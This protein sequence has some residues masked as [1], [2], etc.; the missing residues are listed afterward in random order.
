MRLI[1]GLNFITQE[2]E[3]IAS[4]V[5]LDKVF[6]ARRSKFLVIKALTNILLSGISPEQ[7]DIDVRLDECL[8]LFS[9][10]HFGAGIED[11]F[12]SSN[13]GHDQIVYSLMRVKIM[14]CT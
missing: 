11:Q 9:E 7:F 4:I 8:R 3:L 2:K 13:G 14:D 12:L 10:H 6:A 1:F 5:D